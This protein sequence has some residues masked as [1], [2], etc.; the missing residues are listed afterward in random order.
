MGAK[1]KQQLVCQHCQVRVWNRPASFSPR[2]HFCLTSPDLT[3]T[4]P[5]Q[6]VYRS[7]YR[8]KHPLCAGC[9]SSRVAGGAAQPEPE[10]LVRVSPRRLWGCDGR[11]I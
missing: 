3:T 1:K 5:R 9:R 4:P 11:D 8:G 6:T 10:D 7:R 2:T